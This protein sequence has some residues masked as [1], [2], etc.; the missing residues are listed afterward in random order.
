M[1]QHLIQWSIPAKTFLLGEYVAIIGGPA[2]VL[3][4]APCFELSLSQEPGLQGIHPESPAGLWWMR[5]DEMNMGL[6]W[7]DPYQGRGGMGASSAQ[8]IGAYLATQYLKKTV[9]T[10]QDMLTAY[11]TC[12]WQGLGLRPSGYDVL[13][14]TSRHCVYINHQ[15]DVHQSST[16]AFPDIAFILLHTGQKLATHHHLQ[17]IALPNQLDQLV[18]IVESAKI[19]LDSLNSLQMINAVNAYHQQLVHMNKVAEHSLQQIEELKKQP[20]V[21]AIKGCGAMGADVLLLLVPTQ[22]L[23]SFANYLK[24]EGW[25]VLATSDDLYAKSSFGADS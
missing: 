20:D 1:R 15:N 23:A 14:Q 17:T 8:F 21:L 13:A 25:D 3:T 4:T 18:T 7:H 12:A 2:I 9:P 19:A 6:Q 22:K 5:Q 24:I 16:W 10:Q 11:L